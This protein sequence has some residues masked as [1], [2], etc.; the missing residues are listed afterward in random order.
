MAK[1]A[2][3]EPRRRLDKKEAVRHLI[4][5]AARL[6]AAGEDPFAIHTLVQSADKLLIDLSKKT[7]KALAFRW[8]EVIRSEYRE[9]L[10][11]VHR[12]T[13]NFFKHADKDH[14]AQLHVGN[15]T[16][17][18]VLILAVCISNTTASTAS[19]RITCECS[20]ALPASSRLTDSVLPISVGRA[21][22]VARREKQKGSA[23][24]VRD[25]ELAQRLHHRLHAATVGRYGEH[26]KSFPSELPL[27][28][29][30]GMRR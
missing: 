1:I 21:Q 5:C 6:V 10:L 29:S 24:A 15:I 18:N 17:L 4:H 7:G 30:R 8:D 25:A 20:L 2:R 9:A 3:R 19:G 27:V 28:L 12:E 22:L 14:D 23:G 16:S 13:F 26:A 11:Q